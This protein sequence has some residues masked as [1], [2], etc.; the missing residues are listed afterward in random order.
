[1]KKKVFTEDFQRL[2]EFIQKVNDIITPFSFRDEL[3]AVMDKETRKR[4]SEKYPKCFM[5]VNMN[6][7]D[8]FVLPICNRNGSTDKNMIAFSMKLAN[9]LLDRKDV[10]RGMLEVTIKKLS[11]MNNTYSKDIPTPPG[12]AA[13]KANVTKALNILKKNLDSIRGKGE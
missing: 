6:N 3:K 8:N 7:K 10:D 9:R 11:R 12:P 2:E 1:M 5:P 4:M 13:K